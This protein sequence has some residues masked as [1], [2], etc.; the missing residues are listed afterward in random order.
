M[1]KVKVSFII[2]LLT[3]FL[4]GCFNIPIGDGNKIK[5]SKDGVTITDAEGSEGKISLDQEGEQ[6]NIE[7][8]S[9]DDKFQFG[10]GED[11]NIPDDFPKDIPIPDKAKVFQ[12]SS[13][14]GTSLISYGITMDL[15]ELVALYEKYFNSNV[16]VDEPGTSSLESEEFIMRTFE[17]Q[18]K[19]GRL[20][21]QIQTTGKEED[22]IAVIIYFNVEEE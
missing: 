17:G 21:V 20:S 4:A 1:K 12:A 10:L 6:I 15:D 18:R 7:G 22:E 16:F 3:I 8:F 13:V 19:D 14:D 9:N 2:G 5:I 11:V